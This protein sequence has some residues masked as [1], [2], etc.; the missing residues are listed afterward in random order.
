[1]KITLFAETEEPSETV[2]AAFVAAAPTVI[3]SPVLKT[4]FA[5]PFHRSV[6]ATL[7][8]PE[9]SRVPRAR[10][11]ALRTGGT[12]VVA[13][14]ASPGKPVEP[15]PEGLVRR[16]LTLRLHN[17]APEDLVTAVNFL[18]A[19]RDRYPF[20]AFKGECH[21]LRDMNAAFDAAG[22]AGDKRVAVCPY[23]QPER[24]TGTPG[25]GTDGCLYAPYA[26]TIRPFAPSARPARRARRDTG[27]DRRFRYAGDD[28]RRPFR[29]AAAASPAVPEDAA[30]RGRS[31]VFTVS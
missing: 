5:L 7:Q 3:L 26:V 9:L 17:Y 6:P 4:V 12:G 29:D 19:N 13:G 15:A 16:M 8:V 25:T 1:M 18:E 28:G 24:E 23:C 30:A 31:V 22:K 11:A 20:A 27:R 21:H 14:T 2:Y 10:I